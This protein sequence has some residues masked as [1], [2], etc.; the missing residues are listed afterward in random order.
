MRRLVCA[1]L[2]W[3]LCGCAGLA[4]AVSPAYEGDGAATPEDAVRLYLEGVQRMDLAKMLS[5]FAIE[6][7]AEK[8]VLDELLAKAHAYYFALPIKF[9]ASNELL[10]A[11]NV[12]TRKNDIVTSVI[13][14]LFRF[15]MPDYDVYQHTAFTDDA[16]MAD[17]IAAFVAKLNDGLEALTLQTLRIDGF[18]PPSLASALYDNVGNRSRRESIA[19]IHGAEE[20]ESVI[21]LFTVEETRYMLCCDAIRYGDRWY[22]LCFNGHIGSILAMPPT[23]GGFA[24][25]KF[26]VPDE[27]VPEDV[28]EDVP[29][30]VPEDTEDMSGG[31]PAEEQAPAR[32]YRRSPFPFVP[33]LA[34]E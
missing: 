20:V 19:Q 26:E 4:S 18:Y 21:A 7:Y 27:D 8:T 2:I 22:I 17:E 6:T 10:F 1:L 25:T 23:A 16:G 15:H 24:V 34:A 11:L 30:D 5:A 13:V 3:G 14:Q 33:V 29:V 9:P 31:M 12:E 28:A 32:V